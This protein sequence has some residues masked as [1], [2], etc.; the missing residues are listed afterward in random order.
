[1]ED[2]AVVEL[3]AEVVEKVA[4]DAAE[5]PLAVEGTG[6]HPTE[7]GSED[8]VEIVGGDVVEN[9]GV[10]AFGDGHQE[11][12]NRLGISYPEWI[13]GFGARDDAELEA[14]YDIWDVS[15]D[16][17]DISASRQAEYDDRAIHY[18]ALRDSLDQEGCHV[19]EE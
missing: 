10:D 7:L 14:Q 18:D 17:F 16:G 15:D 11:V 3:I 1:M 2:V 19:D 8:S 9:A 12:H 13:A 5:D 4:K 6:E